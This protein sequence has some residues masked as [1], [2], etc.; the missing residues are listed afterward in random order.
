[1]EEQKYN[2]LRKKLPSS[3]KMKL[4]HILRF[5]GASQKK[6]SIMVGA[7]F[8]LNANRDSSADMKDWNG[9]GKMFYH[10]LFGENPG[11]T[12]II[13]PIRLASQI[14]ACFGKNELNELILK[15][16]PDDKITPGFLHYQLVKLPWRDIF[17]TNY[18]TLIERAAYKE[19]P[20]FTV[21]T[22]RETLLYKPFPRIIKLHGSFKE[23]RPFVISEE[24]YRTY[25]QTHPE[26][27]NTVRQSLI[28]GLLC[29]VG[30]SGNDP[31]FLG[32]IGWLRDVMGDNIAPIYLVNVSS[33]LHE[34]EVRL[35]QQRG[36]SIIDLGWI[37]NKGKDDVYKE[38]LDFFFTYLTKGLNDEQI[39][40]PNIKYR[41]SDTDNIQETIKDLRAIR[42]AYPGWLLLPAK[43]YSNFDNI[44][45]EMPFIDNKFS[46]WNLSD[47]VLVE[48]LYEL[49]WVNQITCSPFN[50][51]WFKESIAKLNNTIDTLP[52]NLKRKLLSLNISLLALYRDSYDKER[53]DTISAFIDKYIS[54]QNASELVRRYTY[55][56]SLFA[57]VTLNRPALIG[58]LNEWQPL[59]SDYLGILWK[60]S[61]LLEIGGEY[62]KEAFE[63]LSKSTKNIKVELLMYNSSNE[64]LSLQSISEQV[65]SIAKSQI[66]FTMDNSGYLN[67]NENLS[68][69]RIT[70]AFRLKLYSHKT[71]PTV[72][73]IHKFRIA[74]F[75]TK[76]NFGGRGYKQEYLQSYRYLKTYERAGFP[77]GLPHLNINPEG[78]SLALSKLFIY[79]LGVAISVLLR[80]QNKDIND[81][82]LN[83][84]LLS[85][86][87]KESAKELFSIFF[88]ADNYR[89]KASENKFNYELYVL[90]I[91]SRL[92]IKLDNDDLS[93]LLEAQL[94]SYLAI[95]DNTSKTEY[96]PEDIRIIYSCMS[97]AQISGFYGHILEIYMN[98]RDGEDIPLPERLFKDITLTDEILKSFLSGLS[99][100]NKKDISKA[101]N[102]I[103]SFYDILDE[104]Q[105]SR[106]NDAIMS[107]RKPNKPTP[108]MLVSFNLVS[109]N[110]E[111]L[112]LLI[113]YLENK[114][115]DFLNVDAVI[116]TNST[117][118]QKATSTLGCLSYA[119]SY[120]DLNNKKKILVKIENVLNENKDILFKEKNN[121]YG[122][123]DFGGDFISTVTRFI[124]SLNQD[125]FE[126]ILLGNIITLLQNYLEHDFAVLGSIVKLNSLMRKPVLSKKDVVDLVKSRIFSNNNHIRHD[127]LNA[128][129]IKDNAPS[130]KDLISE[131]IKRIEIGTN[132]SISN[133]L[134]TLCTLYY[135][136][137]IVDTHL[138]K[139]PNTLETLYNEIQTFPIS[140]T[141]R[142]DIYYFV[143][144][145][146]G[147]LSANKPNEDLKN[148][149]SLWES[150][151]NGS[152]TFNDVRIGFEKGYEKATA[153]Q[154][155]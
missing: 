86:I 57:L 109:P 140:E 85:S 71:K 125:Q 59:D 19:N 148:I 12:T 114:V 150:Y 101:Y 130:F 143:L 26:F 7:G 35:N 76:K 87:S 47:S 119:T 39:W 20:T 56:K 74:S 121:L 110:K 52:S 33:N 29:L 65:L 124:S 50:H 102:G 135:R 155:L 105:L 128:M 10:S 92:S 99:S 152:E 41:W 44:I 54:T 104:N 97:T 34:S 16:L 80:A 45:N 46:K 123:F 142:T 11:P 116:T 144:E 8:S 133:V 153:R 60:S 31:N 38:R 62:S 82:I 63:L 93:Q 145:F 4:D 75:T 69:N 112:P 6:A 111:E 2:E 151:A 146:V 134:S 141:I 131:M 23:I 94:N 96:R 107:W 66:F 25:P 78:I 55:E 147:A 137:F 14:E 89:N 42:K 40:N 113:G 58:I 138:K 36:I 129:L 117:P 48:F 100:T 79:S 3:V 72:Q 139:L 22:N 84:E 68:F 106:V 132:E 88:K 9:L 18:D 64:L 154:E 17:T 28:E 115:L 15:S 51:E 118:I 13:D 24:D 127:A 61:I 70:E 98:T 49:D 53:F 37:S 122:F 91:L 21:V 73:R 32:W 103:A 108:D 5:L 81:E 149:I 77:Y 67:E 30:F 120:L 43:Y 136:G 90:S 126:D 83:R 95:D 27:V 1:M